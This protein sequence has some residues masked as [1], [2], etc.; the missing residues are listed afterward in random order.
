MTEAEKIVATTN[1]SA[2]PPDEER[3]FDMKK[4]LMMSI[5]TFVGSGVVSILGVATGVTGYS[6]W[7]AYLLAV[8]VGFVSALAIMVLS[9]TM[10]FNGGLYSVACT[11]LGERFGGA[12]ALYTL[13]SGMAV[14]MMASAFGAYVNS[15]F[16]S[17]SARVF[18][19]AILLVFWAVQCM[20]IDFMATVQKYSTYILLVAL[21]VFCVYSYTNLNPE[22]F[23]FSGPQFMTGGLPGLL[24]AMS[25]LVF[26]AQS[27]DSN[28]F[29]YAKYT[30]NSRRHMPKVIFYTMLLL[31]VVYVGV[32]IASVGAV[33]LE[34]AAGKP[35]TNPARAILPTP[36]FYAFIVLGPVLCLTT[37]INGVMG[38]NVITLT[39]STEDGWFPK[40]FADKNKRGASWKI[41]T[42]LTTAYI[43]PILF[44]INI[45]W[46]TSNTVLIGSCFQIPLLLSYWRLPDKFP[47][48]F[49]N[50]T[51][52][53]KRG[54]YHAIVVLSIIARL[55]IFYWS[56]Q[57]LNVTNVIIVVSAVVVCFVYSFLRYNTGKTK[58]QY[59]YFFD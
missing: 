14:A 20:G 48:A 22:V 10:T 25:M 36:L 34:T 51:L 13:V 27:Y 39:K 46:L 26:S 11:F 30:K 28:L 6:V 23:H 7:I 54:G 50:N 47:E 52:K 29:P 37:T 16:S 32:A 53:L 43:A 5:G 42:V 56:A 17:A 15:V 1:E 4:L 8:I 24:G 49:A 2:P 33:D 55:V 35:L 57:N 31:I 44:S 18:A 9:G 41:L 21:L 40:S 45:G 3:T 59:S 19:I 12:F 58:L 38:G